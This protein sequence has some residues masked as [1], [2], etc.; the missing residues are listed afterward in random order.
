VRER[1]R[2]RYASAFSNAGGR[3][4]DGEGVGPHFNLN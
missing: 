1:C 3:C 4:M 2:L